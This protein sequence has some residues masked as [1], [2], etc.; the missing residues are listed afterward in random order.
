MKTNTQTTDFSG[1]YDWPEEEGRIAG[2]YYLELISN[3]ESVDYIHQ[4]IMK[5]RAHWVKVFG[6]DEQGTADMR[7]FR[8]TVNSM[9]AEKI[10]I[11]M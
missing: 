8:E 6:T 3:G 2:E 5:D 4:Q 11:F 9:I 7:K 10:N 1:T